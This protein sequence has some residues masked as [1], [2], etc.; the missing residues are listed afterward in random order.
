MVKRYRKKK[1]LF[2]ISVIIFYFLVI[3]FFVFLLVILF[4]IFLRYVFIFFM[5][6]DILLKCLDKLLDIF[7]F[8]WLI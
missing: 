6:F 8:F 4:S 1:S 5:L 2:R 3:I 7:V